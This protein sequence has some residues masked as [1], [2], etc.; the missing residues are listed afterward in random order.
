MV[1]A[2]KSEHLLIGGIKSK[3]TSLNSRVPNNYLALLK[4]AHSALECCINLN[5][6]SLVNETKQIGLECEDQHTLALRCQDVMDIALIYR[7][8]ELICKNV[9]YPCK[10]KT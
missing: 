2:G 6:Y 3:P 9:P 1:T 10:S 7:F 8:L 4:L 5:C